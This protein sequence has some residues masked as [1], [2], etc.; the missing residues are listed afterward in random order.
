MQPYNRNDFIAYLN[1]AMTLDDP[2]L[3]LDSYACLASTPGPTINE[4]QCRAE[5]LRILLDDIPLSHPD[6]PGFV[7]ELTNLQRRIDA[8][9]I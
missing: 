9:A 5:L 2:R 4:M 6:Y 3:S 8:E 7:Q 1:Q